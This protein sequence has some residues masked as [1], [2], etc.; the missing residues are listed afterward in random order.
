VA[1]ELDV[2]LGRDVG[3]AVRFE[4]RS[5]ADTRIRFLTDGCLLREALQDPLLSR[6]NTI[7]LD[8][9]HERSVATDV[10]IG[11]V[12]AISKQRPEL[13]V[14]VSSATLDVS[15]FSMFFEGCPVVSIP[16]RMHAVH[17]SYAEERLRCDGDAQGIVRKAVAAAWQIHTS[18][19]EGDILVFLTGQEEIYHACRLM[20]ETF[21]REA[22]GEHGHSIPDIA[23][24]PVFAGLSR[25]ALDDVFRPR[26][27][28]GRKV[29]FATNVCETSLTVEGIRYVIDPG[30][31]KQKCLV[32][33]CRYFSVDCLTVIPISKVA[34]IQRA[35]RAGRTEE[36]ECLRLYSEE[37][38]S[39]LETESIPEIK[40]SD[41][42]TVVLYL[43]V[44]GIDPNT[45]H[46]LDPPD[47][48]LIRESLH[49][50]FLLGAL[51]MSGNV[52]KLGV[53][54]SR[55]PVSPHVAKFLILAES[56]FCLEDA[57]TL[58]AMLSNSENLW[59]S[60]SKHS[61]KNELRM[62]QS[63]LSSCYG[64]HASLLYI[65]DQ[66]RQSSYSSKWCSENMIHFKF[67]KN[68]RHVR[69]QLAGLFPNRSVNPTSESLSELRKCIAQ[70]FFMQTAYFVSGNRYRPWNTDQ[71]L[72]I[73]PNSSL[74]FLEES[75]LPKWIV[76]DQVMITSKPFMKISAAIEYD[77]IANLVP[78]LRQD[79]FGIK[80]QASSA[81]SVHLPLCT[82]SR[83]VTK[84]RDTEANAEAARQRY[85][86]RKKLRI[87][88]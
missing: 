80:M 48:K 36:G 86:E 11:L 19:P 73:H 44:L 6:Y 30:F 35:G 54:L 10:L 45:F 60:C 14:V 82:V 67:L 64:D 87:T 24:L 8:E 79:P 29:L 76:Y 61:A 15:K 2:E 88:R 23:I 18:K 52:T 59:M 75:K 27:E 51:S 62:C 3:Y 21:D 43:K 74:S 4:D 39:T 53:E 40:R 46:F 25:E 20:G 22:S 7:L 84:R 32:G 81:S 70:A 69:Q 33:T 5:C 57:L 41:L 49:Q 56:R 28:N 1:V 85:L 58:A 68:A 26:P 71:E 55:L 72:W 38:Y 31:V 12:K 42:A 50:L 63:S 66:W 77:W 78:K 65:Y 16:G 47:S 83:V 9:A 17:V 34:S 37:F 13:R